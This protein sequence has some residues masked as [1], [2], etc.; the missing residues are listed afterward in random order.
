LIR[1]IFITGATGFIGKYLA[2]RLAK[3]DKIFALVRPQ[4]IDKATLL[5]KAGIE[6][7]E[8]DLLDNDTYSEKLNGVDYIFHLA[9]LFKLDA[10]K[11]ELYKYNI[12][13]TQRLLESCLGKNLKKI[14]HFST[15][16]VAGIKEAGFIKE[17]EPYPKRFKNWYEWS[18]AESEKVAL[19]FFKK[20]NLPLVIVRPSIVYGPGS[21]YGFYNALDIVAKGKLL[22]YPG[23]GKNRV[24]LIHIED[25]INAVIHIAKLENRIG[26]IYHICDDFPHTS[27][28]LI[29][30]TCQRLGIKPPLIIIPRFLVKLSTKLPFINR[31]VFNGS[32]SRLLDYFIYNQT[33]SNTKL[34]STGFSFTYPNPLIGL[35]STI[36]WFRENKT[37]SC[38]DYNV[39]I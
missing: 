8:G 11:D 32:S 25:L 12:I 7:I 16:Y 35:E 3:E 18:K 20:F 9:A 1:R 13:G 23:D 22:A 37:L 29:N 33:F 31:L 39:S 19:N 24:H 10:R 34:K 5:R 14:V 15:A 17:N 21:T 27:G 26:E 28:E 30:F 38:K 4:S 6:I 2:L 36:N